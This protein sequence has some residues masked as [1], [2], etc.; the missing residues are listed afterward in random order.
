LY[1]PDARRYLLIR[2]LKPR[3]GCENDVLCLQI[4]SRV[5]FVEAVDDYG[6]TLHHII[7]FSKIFSLQVVFTSKH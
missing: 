6:I 4:S 5:P 3:V 2:D 7:V 1:F